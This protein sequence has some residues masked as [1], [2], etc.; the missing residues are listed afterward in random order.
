MYTRVIIVGNAGSGKSTLARTL[1]AKL[2]LPVIHLDAVFW[3]PGW[4]EPDKPEFDAEVLGLTGQPTWVIDG[5]YNRTLDAR[6]AV[7]DLIIFLDFPRR[8]CLWRV[9]RRWAQYRGTSRPDIGAGC[10]EKIDLLFLRWVWNYNRQRQPAVLE[11]LARAKAAGKAVIQLHN[12]QEVR[13]FLWGLPS[14]CNFPATPVSHSIQ[15]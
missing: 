8:L 3:R 9:C 12:P 13:Q 2:E 4:V 7:A 10:P 14:D 6:L 15:P 1:G 11:R 5:N